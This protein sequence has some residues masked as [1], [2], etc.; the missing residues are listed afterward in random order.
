MCQHIEKYQPIFQHKTIDSPSSSVIL[1]ASLGFDCH[2]EHDEKALLNQGDP[3]RP[4]LRMT[5]YGRNSGQCPSSE[6]YR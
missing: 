2:S 5:E 6:W 3:S 1:I 4:L